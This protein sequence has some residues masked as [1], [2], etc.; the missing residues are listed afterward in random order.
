MNKSILSVQIAR[1][2]ARKDVS[3]YLFKEQKLIS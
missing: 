2:E 1:K 3:P